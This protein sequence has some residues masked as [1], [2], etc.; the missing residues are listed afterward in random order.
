MSRMRERLGHPFWQAAIVL[1]GAYLLFRWGV[2]Y[3]PPLFG[4]PSA[5]VP[6][7][8]LLQYMAIA[9]VGVLLHVSS[10]EAR[11]SPSIR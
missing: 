10:D 9:I 4:V 6:Q 1:V 5:P 2:R 7:S 8:V 11:L 3:V